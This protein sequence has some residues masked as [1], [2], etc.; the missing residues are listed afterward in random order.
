MKPV[1]YWV[2]RDFR[3]SDNA[4]LAAACTRGGPVIPV[5]ICDDVV[6]GQGT[7]PKF[8][9]GEGVRVFAKA[10]EAA[11]SRLILRRGKALD[12]LRQIVAETGADAVYWNRLY[13]PVSKA[14]DTGVKAGLKDD[15]IEARSFAGHLLFEPWTVET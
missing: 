9:L 14:R 12:V 15:G 2:R 8:R 13:D 10:L 1:I 4:A 11:G 3:L 5:F 7:A 6:D